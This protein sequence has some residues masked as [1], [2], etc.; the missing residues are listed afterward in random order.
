MSK[1]GRIIN[2]AQPT[3]EIISM[4]NFVVVDDVVEITKT[5]EN[6]INKVMMNSNLEYKIHIFHDYDSNFLKFMDN[7]LPNKIYFLDIETKSASGL[8]IARKIRKDDT[9]SIISFITAHEQMG[10]VIIKES[11]MILTF[12]CK[13]DGFETKVKD[14]VEKS[15][16]I[17]GT[18]K[19]LKFKVYNSLY[20]IPIDDILYIMRDTIERKCIIKTDYTTYKVGKSLTEL[21]DLSCDGLTQTHRACLVNEKRVHKYDKRNKIIIFDT[22]E[23]IDLLSDSHKK[24]LV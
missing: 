7:P 24:E 19:I 8:D 16:D 13:F 4:I 3:K 20:I 14:A 18:K 12:I 9:Q 15:L 10:G 21:K 17:L 5:V 2:V 22:G 11:L 23:K 1:Y 6:I